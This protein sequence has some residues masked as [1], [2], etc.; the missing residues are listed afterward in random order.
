V[1]RRRRGQ[2]RHILCNVPARDGRRVPVRSATIADRLFWQQQT[3]QE[4]AKS[5]ARLREERD[6]A[7]LLLEHITG[8]RLVRALIWLRLVSIVIW[9]TPA[10]PA[11]ITAGANAR[12]LPV[13]AERGDAR[14][15]ATG[16]SS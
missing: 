3:I 8:Q 11:K 1:S 12:E 15:P 10:T 9:A 14:A 13:P 6:D 4:Q 2:Q 7:R 16:I 5:I